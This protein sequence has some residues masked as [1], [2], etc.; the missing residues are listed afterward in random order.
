MRIQLLSSAVD[1]VFEK[2]YA[3]SYLIDETVAVDAGSLGFHGEPE[4]QAKVKNLFITHSHADHIATLPIFVE[5]AYEAKPDC[6]T[7]WGNAAVLKCIREDIFNDRFWPDF[8]RLS[9]PEAP[10]VKLKELKA[11]RPVEVDGLRITPI[12][13]NHQVR[14]FGFSIE[15]ADASVV[16]VSD[17]GPTERVWEVVNEIENLKAVFLEAAFPNHMHDLADVSLHLTPAMF[18]EEV[19]K[20]RRDTRLIVVHLKPRYR[21]EIERELAALGLPSL[22]IGRPNEEYTFR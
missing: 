10:F 22:E 14:N 16:I 20:I 3:T 19:K 9:T 12:L 18:A 7:V 8:E 6:V 1:G 5:N 4:D 15:S 21:R 13:V 11:E 2:Q 17:T